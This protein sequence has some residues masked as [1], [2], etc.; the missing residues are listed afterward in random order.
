MDALVDADAIFCYQCVR[1]M[2]EQAHVVVEIV[3]HTNVGY[4]DPESGLN[5]SEVDYKF[6][7]QFASGALFATSLL[8]TLACQAFYNTKIIDVINKLIGAVEQIIDSKGG[9]V[10]GNNAGSAAMGMQ[11]SALYQISIPEGLESRTYGSLYRLLARRKQIPLGILRGI[12][13]HT[14]SGPKNNKM[15]YVFT[16]PPKDTELFTCDKVFVLSQHPIAARHH[17]GGEEMKEMQMYSNIRS[18]RKTAEDIIMSVSTVQDELHV[19]RSAHSELESK[20]ADMAGEINHKFDCLFHALKVS[21]DPSSFVPPSQH[22]GTPDD[23]NS[24]RPSSARRG[25]RP[26]SAGKS[27]GV[28]FDA[29]V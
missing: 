13:S 18:R 4:L 15:P 10:K 25:G 21:Y 12:Y 2:N 29:A 5:S 27:L 19:F 8:D 16:N 17:R 24:S 23:N 6:T 3:R 26:L 20:V 1:R 9:S 22:S 11:G 14:K 28:S 7:P